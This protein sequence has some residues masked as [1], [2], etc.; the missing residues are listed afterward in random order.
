MKKLKLDVE[1]LAVESFDPES[2]PVAPRGTVKAQSEDTDFLCG[3]NFHSCGWS[4][5]DCHTQGCRTD[6]DTCGNFGSCCPAV[7]W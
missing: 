6:W 7:C 3:T 2:A 4:E 1:T 5:I